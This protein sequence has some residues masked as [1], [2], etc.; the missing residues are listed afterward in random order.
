METSQKN[1]VSK[2]DKKFVKKY[3]KAM[4]QIEIAIKNLS[5]NIMM[6]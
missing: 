6:F 5:N 1:I 3:K 2:E 4:V